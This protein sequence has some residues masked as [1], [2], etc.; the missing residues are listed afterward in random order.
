M[1]NVAQTFCA[2]NIFLI[3]AIVPNGAVASGYLEPAEDNKEKTLPQSKDCETDSESVDCLESSQANSKDDDFDG[4]VIKVYGRYIGLELP[5]IEGRYLLDKE[6][7]ENAP[8]TTG[9]I[10]DLIALLPGVQTSDDALDI[11]N[12]AEIRAQEITISG[13]QVWQTGYFFDGMNYNSRID[14]SSY[15]R[16]ITTQNDVQ[17]G[18]QAFFVNSQVVDSI[19]VY[20]NNIPVEFGGFSGGVVKVNSLAP[21]EDEDIGFNFS[22]RGSSSDWNKYHF[23]EENDDS[24]EDSGLNESGPPVFEK[25]GFDTSL[26]VPLSSTQGLLFSMNYTT[27]E[28]TVYT[29]SENRV[30]DRRNINAL[31]KYTNQDT[32]FDNIS[33]NAFYAPYENNNLRKDVFNSDFQIKGGGSGTTIQTSKNFDSLEWVSNF[34]FSSS[35]NSRRAPDHN[36]IW[37]LARGKEWGQRASRDT[38]ISPEGG[39]G[40]LNKTQQSLSYNNRF[41]FNGFDWGGASHS[42]KAGI[43]LQ[44]QSIQRE[45]YQD[46]YSYNSAVLYTTDINA[47]PLNCSGYQLDCVELSY[48]R[49]LDEL[50]AELGGSI[51]FTN[52][53]HVIAYSNN[54]ATSPQY[55]Q[56]RL[57]YPE[58]HIDVTVRQMSMYLNDNVE[59]GDLTLNLGLRYDYDDFFKNHN[60]APRFSGSYDF[61]GTGGSLLILGASRYYDTNLLSYKI[62]EEQA[63]FYAQFRPIQNSSLQGWLLSSDNSNQRYRFVDVDTPYDDEVVLGWKQASDLLGNFSIKGQYRWKR[64][65]IARGPFELEDDGFRYAYQNNNGSGTSWRISLAWNKKID[66][67]SL[68]ANA[69]F[70]ETKTNNGSYDEQVDEAPLDEI[71]WYQDEN[72]LAT[73]SEVSRLN[74]NFSRPLR[75]N[76]GWTTEWTDTFTTSF[77]GTYVGSYTTA[78]T[79]NEYHSSGNVVTCRLQECQSVNIP[80]DVPI[81]YKLEKRSRLQVNASTQW[82]FIS[83][84]S[85]GDL[86]F[87][88][89]IT[90]LLNERTYQVSPGRN[91]VE[92][93]RTYWFG[94]DYKY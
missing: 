48:V 64:E 5:E 76:F 37:R 57:V 67:H 60:I 83:S 94:L 29:L 10:N 56:F 36:Y 22:Y 27:S 61:F 8:R 53:D 13:G 66:N 85:T 26:T 16:S 73:I 88:A 28:N 43:D 49:P 78:T 14:P 92:L 55:F 4:E 42:F 18:S 72:R 17:G 77:S 33:W 71:V 68:W 63:P 23:I 86:T 80:F 35:E 91:G 47:I 58:E 89:D 11:S 30:T 12:A 41:N 93:G 82:A 2:L 44:Q 70:S 46:T 6:F 40:D 79:N 32:W 45:R 54:I 87:R 75:L 69:S 59:W 74:A 90:N 62:K 51:D 9:D 24:T 39:F 38:E 15:D 19:E 81:Y 1:K 50:I 3:V 21:I 34:N 7:I 25:H 31:L 65:Q 84:E 52:P 20:D